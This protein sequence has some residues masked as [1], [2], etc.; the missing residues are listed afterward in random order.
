MDNQF[1]ELSQS[2]LVGVSRREALRTFGIGIAGALLAAFDSAPARA[3]ES[4]GYLLVSSFGSDSILRYDAVTGAFVDAFVPTKSGGLR[5]PDGVIFGPDGN[6]YVSGGLE[7]DHG[8]G[9]QDVLRYNGSTGDF[10]DDFAGDIQALSQRAILF[11]PDGNLYVTNGSAT[12]ASQGV[13]RFD[14]STG[15]FIDD[16]V[17]GGSGGLSDPTGMVFG[18]DGS[19]DGKLDLYVGDIFASTVLR[20]D[21]TTGAF[22]GV[23]VSGHSGGLSFPYGM[24]FGP[25]GNLYVASANSAHSTVHHIFPAQY[26][27]IRAPLAQIQ[28]HFSAPSFREGAED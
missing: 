9:K 15:D 3:A 10:I 16:F 20:Y 24:V 11:G 28:E 12:R 23:F 17:T 18:P 1:G 25:D 7:P 8:K 26:W 14:G 13:L 27:P 6:L 5:E 21:G 22:K 19:D 4:S 2:L